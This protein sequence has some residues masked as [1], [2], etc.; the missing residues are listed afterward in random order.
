[1]RLSPARH[2]SPSIT[3][4]GLFSNPLSQ[5]MVLTA[6]S[7]AF[8]GRLGVFAGVHCRTDSLRVRIF[9]HRPTAADA[10]PVTYKQGVSSS[11]LLAPT[12]E[13]PSHRHL[14][15]EVLVLVPLGSE[16]HE[17]FT[18]PLRCGSE[19]TRGGPRTLLGK[20]YIGGGELPRC[21]RAV[22]L[23][24][25]ELVATSVHDQSQRVADVVDLDLADP[26]LTG[27]HRE[28]VRVSVGS[29]GRPQRVHEYQAGLRV[30]SAQTNLSA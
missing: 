4:L 15:P 6:I 28:A 17:N 30:P 18:P 20:R 23:R 14:P 27:Q 21:G 9:G 13:T 5:A 24:Q 22:P 3:D 29:D 12:I 11:S 8:H 10:S 2:W 25:Q 26:G 7:T 1:M 19:T 16:F